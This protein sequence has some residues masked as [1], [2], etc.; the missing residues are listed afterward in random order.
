MNPI[1][2]HRWLT[3]NGSRSSIVLED[4]GLQYQ[5]RLIDLSKGQQLAVLAD[6]R[7]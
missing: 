4:R 5:V 7:P 2:M 1:G 6:M 3:P